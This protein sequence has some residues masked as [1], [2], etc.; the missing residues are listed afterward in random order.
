[1][2]SESNLKKRKDSNHWRVKGT[3]RTEVRHVDGSFFPIDLEVVKFT[4]ASGV[5]KYSVR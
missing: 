2:Q 1:M 3:R 5:G 4:N